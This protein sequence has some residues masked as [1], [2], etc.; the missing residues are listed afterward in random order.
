VERRKQKECFIP[1]AK[2]RE[3]KYTLSFLCILFFLYGFLSLCFS[4]FSFTEDGKEKALE[5]KRQK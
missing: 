1:N 2:A 3:E 4:F 5:M